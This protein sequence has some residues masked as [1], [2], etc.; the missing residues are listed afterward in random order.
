MSWYE[1]RERK[2]GNVY[3]LCVSDG[4]GNDGK[5]ITRKKTWR[6]EPGLTAR[7]EEKALQIALS[8]FEKSIKQGFQIDSKITFAEYAD[9]V[10]RTKEL[11]GVKPRTIDRYNELLPRINAAIGHKRI[12]DLR[13]QHLNMFYANLAEDGLRLDTDRATI[14]I[15][16]RR[17]LNEQKMS[18]SELSR[19]AGVSHDT[20]LRFFQGKALKV[21]TAVKISSAMG[22]KGKMLY[23][24]TR[25]TSP[26]SSKTILEHHRLISSILSQAVK[27]M[28][29]E[30]NPASRA[31]PPKVLAPEPDY[32]QP[33]EIDRILDKL[34]CAPIK[35][36][37]CVYL[38]IDTGCRR[39]EVAGLKW[40]DIDLNDGIVSIHR[41]LHYAPKR[42]IY[43]GT[44]KND[45]SR[46]L[47]IS[48]QT[49]AVLRQHLL[50]QEKLRTANGERWEESGFVFTQEH[51][52]PMNP[53]SITGW[54]RKFSLDKELPHIH[55]HAF[56]HTAAS[57][58]ISKGIDI[59]TA[60]GE[61]GHNPATT[62]KY[63]A[64]VINEAKARASGVRSSAFDHWN[65]KKEEKNNEDGTKA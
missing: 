43:D 21:E 39:A 13:P 47:Q 15:D 31:S 49:I 52:K 26:L 48:P 1:K 35:W 9:Y 59:V 28:L 61:L 57:T 36:K 16:G 50:E 41:N 42:G 25:D 64:H 8:E 4:I 62:E 7:Q 58:M 34:E 60:A 38:L 10:I 46:V 18:L 44:T 27:E 51:G 20:V 23:S 22:I 17:W 40:T 14:I 30:H 12:V 32:Y 56:R 24:V 53:G 63:Y 37:A 6:P 2:K 54:L 29:I 45:K 19:R 5:Q 33:E 3:R 65:Q 55:P 11:A